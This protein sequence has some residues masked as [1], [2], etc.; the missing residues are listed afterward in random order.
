MPFRLTLSS[1]LFVRAD[2]EIDETEKTH[3]TY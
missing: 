2:E 1:A 3:R